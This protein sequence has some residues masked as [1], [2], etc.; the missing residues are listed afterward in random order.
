MRRLCLHGKP[1][2][3]VAEGGIG[4]RELLPALD[5]VRMKGKKEMTCGFHASGRLL[6]IVI[7]GL[8]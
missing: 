4:G 3:T 7:E 6:G 1:R 5:Q 8:F 2:A